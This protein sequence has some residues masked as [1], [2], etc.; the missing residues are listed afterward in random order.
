MWNIKALELIVQKLRARS[1]FSKLIEIGPLVLEKEMKIWKVYNNDNIDDDDVNKN[2]DGQWTNFDLSKFSD[3]W[4][5][6]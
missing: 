3:V 4:I 6:I 1:K 2:N 5:I